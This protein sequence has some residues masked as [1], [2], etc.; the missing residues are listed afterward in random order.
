MRVRRKNVA[1]PPGGT[2]RVGAK[3]RGTGLLADFWGQA[4]GRTPPVAI[5]A[6]DTELKNSNTE[7]ILSL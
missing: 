5:K 6:A 2:Y 1:V 4:N 7:G 3:S